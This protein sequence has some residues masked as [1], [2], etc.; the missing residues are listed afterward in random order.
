M[1]MSLEPTGSTC[2][3]GNYR[4]RRTNMKLATRRTSSLENGQMAIGHG[5]RPRVARTTTG[6][7]RLPLPQTARYMSRGFKSNTSVFGS[8]SLNNTDQTPRT[9]TT[10][11]T[12]E[13]FV[14]KLDPTTGSWTWAYAFQGQSSD[15]A[16]ALEPAPVEACMSLE[17]TPATR[18]MMVDLV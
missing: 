3:L 10:S 6:G 11:P 14:G 4:L 5:F 8:V 13:A 1:S 17:I 12:S 2:M 18:F 7:Q 15:W 9:L 16:V